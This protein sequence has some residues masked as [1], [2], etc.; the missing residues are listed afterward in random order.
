MIGLTFINFSEMCWSYHK[1]YEWGSIVTFVHIFN[2]K[3]FF[4]KKPDPS[5][6]RGSIEHSKV[7]HRFVLFR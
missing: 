2:S 1:N 4:K 7:F 3:T 5:A 6:R